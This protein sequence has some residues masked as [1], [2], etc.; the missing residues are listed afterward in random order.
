MGR[1]LYY[2]DYKVFLTSSSLKVALTQ[3]GLRRQEYTKCVMCSK[4]ESS[5]DSE[6]IKTGR[7]FCLPADLPF[8]SSP[9]SEGIKTKIVQ[10]C[11]VVGCLKVAL[12][13]KGL[14]L[15]VDA[16]LSRAF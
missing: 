7:R 5:P 14:R 15:E 3:K 4:F 8:E 1:G 2:L 12:T 10:R 6:G 16:L 13:Q 9:D 11:P